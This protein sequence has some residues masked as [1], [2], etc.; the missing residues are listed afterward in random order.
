MMKNITKELLRRG[1]SR[2]EITKIWGG[3]FMRVMREVQAMA[4]V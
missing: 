4:E 2:E 1:Y 3:N